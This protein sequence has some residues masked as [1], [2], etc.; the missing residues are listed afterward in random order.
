MKVEI[1][2]KGYMGLAPKIL[3]CH[4]NETFIWWKRGHISLISSFHAHLPDGGVEKEEKGREEPLYQLLFAGD[5]ILFILFII[6]RDYAL[7]SSLKCKVSRQYSFQR[8]SSFNRGID[9]SITW[10]G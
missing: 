3:S 5:A 4:C 7:K 10:E 6:T 2:K 1:T 9:F 8:I